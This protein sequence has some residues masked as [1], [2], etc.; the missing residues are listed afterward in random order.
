MKYLL[1]LFVIVSFA[2]CSP[3]SAEILDLSS[4]IDEV[5]F[6]ELRAD[7]KTLLP[8][9]QAKMRFRVIAYGAD[10][11]ATYEEVEEDGNISYV[12][13]VSRDTFEIPTDRLPEGS[14]KLF[15]QDGEE[16]KN[17][18]YSTTDPTI[19]TLTFY[20]KIGELKSNELQIQIRELPEE[21]Y[22]EIVIPVIFHVLVPAATIA[23]SYNVSSA[24]L[25]KRIEQLNNIFNGRAT[26]DPNG[27]NAKITFRLAEY[28]PSGA[29]L[30][31]VGKNKVDID[32]AWSSSEYEDYIESELIWDPTKYLNIWLAD[33]RSNYGAP[34]VRL[35]GTP[36]IDGL[37]TDEVAGFTGDD[38]SRLTD[39]GVLVNIQ[40]FLDTE[41]RD[42][43]DISLVLGD[44]FGLLYTDQDDNND[45]VNGDNDYCADT[46]SYYSGYSSGVYKNNR[47]Y[48]EDANAA[49][50]WFTS[51]NIM[52]NYSF[53]N[54]ITVDQAKRIRKVLEQ[55]PS[56]WAYKSTWAFEGK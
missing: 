43:F 5:K 53:K 26:T 38:V 36:E 46:Y 23:P 34:N 13:G 31:E 20:A 52:D 22:E 11:F 48:R 12:E 30:T 44:Y 6:I 32:E 18:E 54:S 9:G 51:F 17:M 41:S 10:D 40:D 49:Y 28:S 45:F 35:E 27:G 25:Q 42:V 55:C 33:A 50:E 4:S 24:E 8:N 29:L 7:H 47:L 14:I 19:R 2:A 21:D 37:N 15:T 3:D 1:L 16:I 39:V 56:R